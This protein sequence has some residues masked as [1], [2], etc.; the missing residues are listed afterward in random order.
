[1][2]GIAQPSEFTSTISST[3]KDLL[4]LEKNRAWHIKK[5]LDMKLLKKGA[6]I[7][8]RAHNFSTFRAASCSIDL[9]LKN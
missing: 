1:M 2:H 6:K 3:V 5:K 7:L 9:Q 4:S 8:T